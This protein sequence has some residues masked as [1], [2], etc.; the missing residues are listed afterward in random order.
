M[1]EGAGKEFATDQKI[2]HKNLSIGIYS[3]EGD[4]AQNGRSYT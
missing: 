1:L 4:P 3:P 2:C